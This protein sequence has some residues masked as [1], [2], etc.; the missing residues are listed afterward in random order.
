[1]RRQVFVPLL[2]SRIFG[3]EMEVFTT[4]DKRAVH[5]RGHDGPSEDAAADGDLAGEGAFLVYI[6][7]FSIILSTVPYHLEAFSIGQQVVGRSFTDISS[8]NRRLRR[9]EAQPD[10]L[11]PSPSSRSH[12]LAL[13]AFDFRIQEDVGL[14][15][16]GAFRLHGQFGRHDCGGG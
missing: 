2:V 7:H 11:I 12:T 14:L 9:P 1:M 4:D 15:L 3:D 6:D 13:R 10:I 5:F 8:L 16:E